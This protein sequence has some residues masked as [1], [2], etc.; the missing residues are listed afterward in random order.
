MVAT[1]ENTVVQVNPQTNNGSLVPGNPTP[2]YLVV[3]I[4]AAIMVGGE[5]FLRFSRF[6]EQRVLSGSTLRGVHH[7]ELIIPSRMKTRY[8]DV[9]PLESF[10][11][12]RA[13]LCAQQG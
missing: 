8:G 12:G 4:E 9:Q 13:A 11:P 6:G 10:F 3:L 7:G 1:R 5:Q 2:L